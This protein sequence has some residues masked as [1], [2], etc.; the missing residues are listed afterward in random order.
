MER[1]AKRPLLDPAAFAVAAPALWIAA[2]CRNLPAGRRRS[3][4]ARRAGSAGI[5]P[6]GFGIL[7]NPREPTAQRSAH[8]KAKA[9]PPLAT[10]QASDNFSVPLSAI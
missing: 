5:L 7:P 2:G 6:A 1:A 4:P 10:T 9:Q 8:A 3:P